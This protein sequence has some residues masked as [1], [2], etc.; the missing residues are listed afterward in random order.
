MA[1]RPGRTAAP[2][3]RPWLPWAV[4][5]AVALVTILVGPHVLDTRPPPPKAWEVAAQ[6]GAVFPF[7]EGEGPRLFVAQDVA[8]PQAT[9]LSKRVGVIPAEPARACPCIPASGPT[10]VRATAYVFREGGTLLGTNAPSADAQ[11]FR[12]DSY[13]TS[14][15]NATWYLGEGAAPAGTQKLPE[16][17][18]PLVARL[19][20]E[21]AGLGAGDLAAVAIHDHPRMGSLGPLFVALRIEAV[22]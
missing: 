19:R 14:L 13:F 2:R 10:A 16:A 18:A 7:L 15:P 8:V 22:G 17:W 4:G 20:A 3:S 12:P 6:Q 5:G 11:R 1:R 9:W 21:V